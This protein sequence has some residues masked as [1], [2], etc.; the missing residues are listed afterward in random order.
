MKKINTTIQKEKLIKPGGK[1]RILGGAAADVDIVFGGCYANL[2]GV[3]NNKD[4]GTTC[5]VYIQGDYL[6]A[7]AQT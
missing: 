5:V 4:R 2:E 7:I 3:I 1:T 6:G